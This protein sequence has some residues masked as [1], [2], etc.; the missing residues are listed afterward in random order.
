MVMGPISRM[1]LSL[2]TICDL[3][4]LAIVSPVPSS[5]IPGLMRFRSLSLSLSLSLSPSLSVSP[6]LSLSTCIFF[7]LSVVLISRDGW[8]NDFSLPSD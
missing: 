6:S 2:I 1:I 4:P 7:S 8:S 5:L 3:V